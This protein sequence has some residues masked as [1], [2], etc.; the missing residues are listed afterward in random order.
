MSWSKNATPYVLP[1]GRRVT[2]REYRDFKRAGARQAAID[3]LRAVIEEEAATTATPDNPA[4]EATDK[5]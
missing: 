3:A 2:G 5:E 4:D 1:D